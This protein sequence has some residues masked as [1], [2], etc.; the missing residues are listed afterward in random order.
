MELNKW[1]AAK[2]NFNLINL[3]RHTIGSGRIFSACIFVP[4]FCTLSGILNLRLKLR[5]S[6]RPKRPT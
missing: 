1:R 6:S 5:A 4:P 2:D 3:P